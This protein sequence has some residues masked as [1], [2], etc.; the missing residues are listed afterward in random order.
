MSL[1]P[2][3]SGFPANLMFLA[4]RLSNF[5]RNTSRLTPLNLTAATADVSAGQ[6][7]TVV[8]PPN[9]LVDLDTFAMYFQ[10]KAGTIDTTTG[11]FTSGTGVHFPKNIE[12]IIRNLTVSSADRTIDSIQEY[13]RLFNVVLDHTAGQDCDVRRKVMSQGGNAVQQI[14]ESGTPGPS[15]N[16]RYVIDNWLGFLGTA[17]PRTLDTSLMNPLKVTIDL[18]PSQILLLKTA[19]TNPTYLLNDIY[20]TID[21]IH[22]MDN[23]LSS[24]YHKML[25]S[26]PDAFL[27]VPFHRWA[28]TNSVGGATGSTNFSVS[29][30]SLDMVISI[31]SPLVA[32]APTW[33]D[34]AGI[35]TSR[36]LGS[37]TY[38]LRPSAFASTNNEFEVR[39]WQYQINGK[40]VPNWQMKND[41]TFAN[42]MK[43]LQA[44]TDLLGGITTTLESGA[45]GANGYPV[46]PLYPVTKVNKA[47][48]SAYS[49]FIIRLNN[50]EERGWISGWNTAGTVAT[51]Q[52]NW[53]GTGMTKV[54]AAVGPLQIQNFIFCK[55]TSS[56]ILKY[57]REIDVLQ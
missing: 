17:S 55:C 54:G 7:I 18:A 19:A 22:V 41:I 9:A 46:A 38:F 57:G 31:F 42:N 47:Y 3:A 48:M 29:S 5:S 36:A 51:S 30:Q 34:S 16:A 53:N 1:V 14:I 44:N 24:Q 11:A 32:S 26:S 40:S 21:T 12:S 4:K 37:S 20:F 10:G 8:T 2:A 39:D 49:A 56:L 6:P 13:N 50:D 28:T 45:D 43:A 25:A 52:F 15:D 33:S 27:E 23:M 35:N